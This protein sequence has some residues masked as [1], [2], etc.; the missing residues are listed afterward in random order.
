M[1]N[2][3]CHDGIIILVALAILFLVLGLAFT[4][5]PRRHS[6]SKGIHN[7][8]THEFRYNISTATNGSEQNLECTDLES[9]KESLPMPID[10]F[11]IRPDQL[12]INGVLGKGA[13]DIVRLGR[14]R[15]SENQGIDVAVKRVKGTFR[16]NSSAV[17][18]L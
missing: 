13:Y 14:Y 15:I 8:E 5:H 10:R 1:K 6:K 3:Y 9:Q 2:V 4:F 17:K 12:K 18:P 11:E 7:N 16:D